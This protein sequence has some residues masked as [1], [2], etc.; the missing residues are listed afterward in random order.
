MN[1]E[2]DKFR[3]VLSGSIHSVD[4]KS[5][6]YFRVFDYY[7]KERNNVQAVIF[8]Y[9]FDYDSESAVKFIPQVLTSIICRLNLNGFKI[10]VKITKMSFEHL[11][12]DSKGVNQVPDDF[13]GYKSLKFSWDNDD[14]EV[15]G[16]LIDSGVSNSEA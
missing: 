3:M 16:F 1:E 10:N 4:T 5:D 13:G 12:G 9:N 7:G 8:L 14:K 6:I 15:G 2:D 11:F